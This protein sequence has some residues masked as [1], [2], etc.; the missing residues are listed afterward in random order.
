MSG[1]RVMLP[2]DL[3][4]MILNLEHAIGSND[5]SR[6]RRLLDSCPV[7]QDFSRAVTADGKKTPLMLALDGGQFHI[8]SIL[9]PHPVTDVNARDSDGRTALMYP[10]TLETAKL[11]YKKGAEVDYADWDGQT[12]LM[13]ALR[14]HD[15]NNDNCAVAEYLIH[16][17]AKHDATDG[18][19]RSVFIHA[20][21]QNQRPFLDSVRNRIDVKKSD[22]RKRT[23]LHHLTDD[24]ARA[25]RFGKEADEDDD[26]L[27]MLLS[28]KFDPN[29]Q[30]WL[31][32]T[33]L[34]SA[35]NSGNDRLAMKLLDH[36]S[37]KIDVKI[38]S[39]A[40]WSHLH[41]ACAQE[42][43]G[44]E[45]VEKLI[46]KELNPMDKTYRTGKTALH[47]AASAGN[48]P[49]VRYLLTL[50][51]V[52]RYAMDAYGNTPLFCVS[53]HPSIGRTQ[54]TTLLAPWSTRTE[55]PSQ[56][57]DPNSAMKKAAEMW[58]ATIVDFD[59]R[60]N[61]AVA[62]RVRIRQYPVWDVI[63]KPQNMKTT[64]D[65]T[66]FR[67][68]AAQHY[69]NGLRWI[70][71]PANNSTW[72]R[73]LLA[74]V[75]IEKGSHDAR[76]FRDLERALHYQHQ[77]QQTHLHSRYM[78]PMCQT[79]R[80]LGEESKFGGPMRTYTHDLA[81][82]VQHRAAPSIAGPRPVF[83]APEASA[84]T[85]KSNDTERINQPIG[86]VTSSPVDSAKDSPNRVFSDVPI[87]ETMLSPG[88]APDQ[89]KHQPRSEDHG[90]ESG[91][92]GHLF[93]FMPYLHNEK[94][95]SREQMAKELD[96]HI[97]HIRAKELERAE[98]ALEAAIKAR[99][100]KDF[101]KARIK[102][103]NKARKRAKQPRDEESK[104]TEDFQSHNLASKDYAAHLSLF[105]AHL[106]EPNQTLHIRRTL[107][108]FF[109]HSVDTSSR[110]M[111]Q[112]VSRFQSKRCEDALTDPNVLMVDQLWIW[113][114]DKDLVITSFPRKWHDSASDPDD[115]LERVK[116]II[117]S[118]SR[119]TVQNVYELAITIVGCCAGAQDGQGGGD[120]GL[121]V[122]NMFESE[123]GAAMD[124]EVELFSQ[125][126]HDAE[127]ASLWLEKTG[128]QKMDRKIRSLFKKLRNIQDET[129]DAA[130]D[131]PDETSTKL[132]KAARKKKSEQD[133]LG[134]VHALLDIGWETRLLK[135]VKDIRDELGMLQHLFS[136]Q[137]QVIPS[138]KTA[139]QTVYKGNPKWC[140]LQRF[141][142]E[143]FE[144]Q[145]RMYTHPLE[146]IRALDKQA[147][148]IYRSIR[149]LLDLKQKHVNALE[150][151]YARQQAQS[152]AKQGRTL[153]VFTVVTV[154]FLPLS[155]IA[156]FFAIPI[157][158]YPRD[159]EA[160]TLPLD[161]VAKYMFGVGVP[162][163]LISVIAALLVGFDIL[164]KDTWA[165]DSQ[166][167]RVTMQAAA[168]RIYQD[169]RADRTDT[170]FGRPYILSQRKRFAKRDLSPGDSV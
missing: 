29:A 91:G 112:V 142:E 114:I 120:N 27:E 18:E 17:G 153:M 97:E 148:L 128:P 103:V 37:Q 149:D 117:S 107:D 51:K 48:V 4:G 163:A 90:A 99:R 79:T 92:L 137:K 26:V 104:K 67:T 30:D 58:D 3:D 108:Q 28:M 49:V 141:A 165:A 71:L 156:A 138:F 65:K 74:K 94:S 110:D 158:E 167:N 57:E 70:H 86:N 63:H 61:N 84:G 169:H 122:L 13:W 8:A 162:V 144:E 42:S 135:D 5:E 81:N 118:G 143:K 168:E 15:Y 59:I 95:S 166:E 77:G 64:Q 53:E 35:I 88:Q 22:L 119:D 147:E 83:P 43:I 10:Q 16:R 45:I 130:A 82:Y 80:Q 106:K 52:S 31:G 50:D 100:T 76:G 38:K 14:R 9:I 101:I 85:R 109:Y 68:T 25:K 160:M 62:D 146:N 41:A 66:Y 40:G 126:Q 136:V 140:H 123:V 47:L 159:Q 46:K 145:E 6:V 73:D 170:G 7:D 98:K 33:C 116:E 127:A 150:A 96:K 19:G 129:D 1:L 55:G 23:A 2:F 56:A 125:F 60:P 78:N 134:S 115:V 44:V 12:V 11:C 151:R 132:D 24:T 157:T 164:S 139:I 89:F 152:S 87:M 34:Y 39:Y 93:M 20:L 161:W 155:F 121:Q 75:F 131:M 32:R 124:E 133:N 36:N 21:W 111:D 113:V 69:P 102:D 72:C 54:I 154:V 105:N